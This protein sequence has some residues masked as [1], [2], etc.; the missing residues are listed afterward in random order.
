M[1]PWQTLILIALSLLPFLIYL[2]KPEMIGADTYW[3]IN[4]AC[5]IMGHKSNDLLFDALN[6]IMP[7]NIPLMKLY[8]A[9]LFAGFVFVFAKIGELYDP[10]KGWWLG[11]MACSFSFIITEFFMYQNEPI[12]Y[13]LFALSL[14]LVIKHSMKKNYFFLSISIL[15]WLISGLFWKGTIYWGLTLI[16]YSPILAVIIIPAIIY[17]WGQYWWFMYADNSIAFYVPLIGIIYL[18]ITSLFLFGL[19]KSTKKQALMWLISIPYVLFV[20]RLYVISVPSAL[21]ISFNAIRTLKIRKETVEATLVT[22]TLFM[23]IFWGMHVFQEFPTQGDIDLVR[24]L[25][26]QTDTIENSFG[27]GYF[28]IYEGFNVSSYGWPRLPN[29]YNLIGYV[30]LEKGVDENRCPTIQFSENLKILKC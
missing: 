9:A 18:G 8:G 27:P 16:I 11:L 21:I 15:L 20:Q 12:A 2:F 5:G 26:E 24:E 19:L 4:Q 30:V 22:F 1:K 10:E 17:Y 23:A 25:R 7:C 13:L 6:S 14:Y 3:Y 28:L 29:D